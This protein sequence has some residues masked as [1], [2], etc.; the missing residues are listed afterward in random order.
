MSAGTEQSPELHRG[1][2]IEANNDT[3]LGTISEAQEG[4]FPLGW[5][6]T[7]GQIE[8]Y[9]GQTMRGM[10]LLPGTEVQFTVDPSDTRSIQ[11]IRLNFMDKYRRI[12]GLKIPFQDFFDGL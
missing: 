11:S 9:N 1:R 6:F 5:V 2:L 10:G 8:G 3:Y 12:F 7:F 4:N